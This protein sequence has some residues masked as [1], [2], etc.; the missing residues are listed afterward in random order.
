MLRW[1]RQR[2]PQ[3]K[4]LQMPTLDERIYNADQ[5]RQVLENSAFQQAFDDITQELTEQ[6]KQS[7]ARDAEG[8]E[9]LYQLLRLSEKYRA[10]LT[11]SLETGRLARIEVEHNR[12][13]A[14]RAKALIGLD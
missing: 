12:T 5:A 10:I 13:L 3:I 4:G 8:R 7:P 6:W 1:Q 9:K 2:K 14:E 11:T